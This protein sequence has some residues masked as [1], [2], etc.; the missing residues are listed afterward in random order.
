MGLFTPKLSPKQLQC[1]QA[2]LTQLNDSVK[3]IN[4][5]VKP[6]VFFKR[7]HF[8]LD[9]LLDLRQYE[10]Y[11]IFK[12]GTPTQDYQKIIANMEATVNDFIDRAL[13]ANQ[14]KIDSL[15]TEKAKKNN[16]EKFIIA[17]IAAFDIADT[18]WSGSKGYPHYTGPLFTENNYNRVKVLFYELDNLD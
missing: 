2:K 12:S 9:L 11:K 16:Y 18:F 10:K 5:T 8:T 15:K 14:R 13:E 4:S 1:V 17:L 6:D 3:L 7:L